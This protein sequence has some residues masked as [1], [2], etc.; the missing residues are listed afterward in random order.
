MRGEAKTVSDFSGN[1]NKE[2]GVVYDFEIFGHKSQS[3][4]F[5]ITSN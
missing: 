1:V 5:D 3:L 2:G 4:Y